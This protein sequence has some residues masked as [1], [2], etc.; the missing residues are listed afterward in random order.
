MKPTHDCIVNDEYGNIVV[1]IRGYSRKQVNDAAS[2]RMRHGY[3][4]TINKLTLYQERGYRSRFDYLQ[5]VARDFKMEFLTVYN[6]A[7]SLG[8][9]EDFD[10]LIIALE[11]M[12]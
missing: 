3:T 5:S 1:I 9:S 12:L 7:E 10:G 2:K 4:K 11:D 6:L 8:Q